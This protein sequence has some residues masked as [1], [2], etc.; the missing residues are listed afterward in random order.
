[1]I[2][3]P[4][5]TENT[6]VPILKRLGLPL[7]V[8]S[9]AT[10]TINQVQGTEVVSNYHSAHKTGHD[11]PSKFYER[12]AESFKNTGLRREHHAPPSVN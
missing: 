1:M 3:Y 9:K 2:I 8:F 5:K 7:Q 11:N 6:E 10:E 12:G 4:R